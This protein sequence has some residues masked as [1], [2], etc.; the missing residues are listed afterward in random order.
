M[1]LILVFVQLYDN[2]R[3]HNPNF[4]QRVHAVHGDVLD[5]GLGLK[6][7]CRALLEEE[8]E[9]VIHSAATVRFD[10]HLRYVMATFRC[11]V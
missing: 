2:L 8:T 5:D 10:E 1:V 11:L 3:V 9:I 4:T 7:K 6:D